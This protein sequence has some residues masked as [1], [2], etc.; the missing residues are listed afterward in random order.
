VLSSV[1]CGGAIHFLLAGCGSAAYEEAVEGS[2]DGR[3][4]RALG[5]ASSEVKSQLPCVMGIRDRAAN[6]VFIETENEIYFMKYV[7][8]SYSFEPLK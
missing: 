2:A 4:L 1:C 3:F 6:C 7:R 8:N 5:L